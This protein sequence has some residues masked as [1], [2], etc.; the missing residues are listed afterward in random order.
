[1]TVLFTLYYCKCQLLI[2]LKMYPK[3]FSGVLI[4][5]SI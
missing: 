1:M 5:V 2:H 3:C 4:T